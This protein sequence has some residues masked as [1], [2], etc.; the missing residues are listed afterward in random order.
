MFEACMIEFQRPPRVLDLDEHPLNIVLRWSPTRIQTFVECGELIVRIAK[1]KSLR[2]EPTQQCDAP[3]SS[4]SFQST[5]SFSEPLPSKVETLTQRA[6]RF[7]SHSSTLSLAGLN[8]KKWW[9][10]SSTLAEGQHLETDSRKKA[11]AL[12]KTASL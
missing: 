1:S 11:T 7:R 10:F 8:R 12:R 5:R 4:A 9:R 3:R 2:R 6:H